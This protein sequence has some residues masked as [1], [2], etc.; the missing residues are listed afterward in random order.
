MK[1]IPGKKRLK[2]PSKLYCGDT[3]ANLMKESDWV[4]V[5]GSYYGRPLQIHIRNPRE[6]AELGRYLLKAAKWM[7]R[8]TKRGPKAW[9]EEN[10]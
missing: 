2:K 9:A 6:A 10:E 1:R 7:R 4:Y 5:G 3:Y 8:K